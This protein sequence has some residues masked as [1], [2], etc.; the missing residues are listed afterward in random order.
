M[1][2]EPTESESKAEIDRFCEAMISIRK[3]IREIETG[4]C[5]IE[6]SALRQ[7]PHSVYDLADDKWGRDYSPQE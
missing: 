2:I 5:Q 3:E 6:H 1:M 7:A 4:N